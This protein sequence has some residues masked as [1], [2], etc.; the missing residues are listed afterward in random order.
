MEDRKVLVWLLGGHGKQKAMKRSDARNSPT[1]ATPTP[2]CTRLRGPPQGRFRRRPLP[3][4]RCDPL[5]PPRHPPPSQL[6][7]PLSLRH[8][9]RPGLLPTP[10][11]QVTNSFHLTPFLT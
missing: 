4:P 5:P 7:P 6:P 2:R 10:L 8:F 1:P 3:S 11:R 9:P